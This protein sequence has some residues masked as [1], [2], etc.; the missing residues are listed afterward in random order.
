MKFS[1]DQPLGDPDKAARKLMEIAN[2]SESVQED[3]QT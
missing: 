1:T 2:A 3:R